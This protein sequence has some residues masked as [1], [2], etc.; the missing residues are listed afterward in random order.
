MSEDDL[1]NATATT[2]GA[3]GVWDSARLHDDVALTSGTLAGGQPVV[4]QP[5]TMGPTPV[6]E[7]TEKPRRLTFRATLIPDA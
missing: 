2:D 6:D 7:T 3:G 1:Y 4:E 5:T